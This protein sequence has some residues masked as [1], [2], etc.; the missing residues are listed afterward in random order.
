MLKLFSI[1][2]ILILI[3]TLVITQ[4]FFPPS[5]KLFIVH[6]DRS[7]FLNSHKFKIECIDGSYQ[8]CSNYVL[9]PNDILLGDDLLL[10]MK[11]INT[12]DLEVIHLRIISMTFFDPNIDIPVDSNK[13]SKKFMGYL[14]V[15]SKLYLFIRTLIFT[16]FCLTLYFIFLKLKFYQSNK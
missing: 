14:L 10:E 15:Q 16:L 8:F 12:S 2:L 11:N 9:Y 1:K 6:S 7:A 13:I 3:S 5:I 4:F